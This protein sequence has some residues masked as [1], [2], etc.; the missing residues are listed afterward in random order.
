MTLQSGHS[1]AKRPQLPRASLTARTQGLRG[2]CQAGS[3]ASTCPPFAA[4]MIRMP[5]SSALAIAASQALRPARVSSIRQRPPVIRLIVPSS[6]V[7][8]RRANTWE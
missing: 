6:R 5:I 1:P 4:P 8:W 2:A 3:S 7:L